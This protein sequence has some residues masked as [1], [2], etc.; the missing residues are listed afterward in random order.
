MLELLHHKRNSFITTVVYGSI[1]KKS[2]K[3]ITGEKNRR[4]YFPLGITMITL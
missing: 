3:I 1:F 2:F 4:Y